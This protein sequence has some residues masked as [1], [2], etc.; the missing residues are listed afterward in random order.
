MPRAA[1]ITALLAGTGLFALASI[2]KPIDKVEASALNASAAQEGSYLPDPNRKHP[3]RVL[4]GDEHVHT[5][6]SMDAGVSGAVLSPEDAVRF[7]RGET[8]KSN[9]GQM[10]KLERPHDWIAV[11]DHSD[12]MGAIPEMLGRNPEFM[13]DPTIKKWR[14]M[15]DQGPQQAM[16]A[17]IELVH[18]QATRTMPKAFMDEKWV[19]SAWQ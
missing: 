14:E 18:A 19:K 2:P 3:E 9:T 11:T 12:G 17:T 13:A 1:F 7:A 8:V 6:W 10:A 16:A 5:G 4:W 15:M